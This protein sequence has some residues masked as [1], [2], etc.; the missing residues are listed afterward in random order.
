MSDVGKVFRV[1]IPVDGLLKDVKEECKNLI[2]LSS[3]KKMCGNTFVSKA[4]ELGRM[5]NDQFISIN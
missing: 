3:N 5:T 2:G 1:P 4:S